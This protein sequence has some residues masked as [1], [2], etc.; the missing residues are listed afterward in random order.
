MERYT[1]SVVF[2][3]RAIDIRPKLV[4]AHHSLG[5]AYYK[6]RRY[7]EAAQAFGKAISLEPEYAAARFHLG[8]TCVALGDRGAALKQ[9][10]ILQSLDTDLARNLYNG[11]HK[12]MFLVV[13]HK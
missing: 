4:E 1:E 5:V 2:F 13:P 8:A 7:G 9:Y 3:K 10:R 6:S 11:I 12:G